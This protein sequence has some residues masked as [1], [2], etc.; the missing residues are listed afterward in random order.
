MPKIGL[1]S[2][3]L[4]KINNAVKKAERKTTGEISLA[5][6]KESYDYAAQE[7][8][9][10]II[11]GF[12]YFFTVVFF[13]HPIEDIIKKMFWDYSVIHLLVFF[14][15]STFMVILIFY[16]LANIPFIN[17]LIVSKKLMTQKV[18]ERAVRYFMESGTVNTREHTGI[19]IFMSL[20]ERRVELLAD[21]GIARKIPQQQWES[22]IEHIT[23]GIKSGRFTQHLIEALQRCG[24]LL[25][26]HFPARSDDINELGDDMEILEK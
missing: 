7:L 12:L 17:R 19:L 25:S 2:G 24:D 15:L 10:G 23:T 21:R 6:I 20:L 5:F 3:D 4:E 14:G 13:A 16:L 11:C 1:K 26:E 22:I 9:F 18:N 8:M